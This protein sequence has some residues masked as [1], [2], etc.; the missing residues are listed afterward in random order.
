MG[1]TVV[2]VIDRVSEFAEGGVDARNGFEEG[3]VLFHRKRNSLFSGKRF[4][5]FFVEFAD[6]DIAILLEFR[7]T[8]SALA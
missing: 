4:A 1:C 8:Y 2:Q 7:Y 3:S 5:V 6:V